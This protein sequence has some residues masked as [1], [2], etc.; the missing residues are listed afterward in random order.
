MWQKCNN[1]LSLAREKGK[2]GGERGGKIVTIVDFTVDL[3]TISQKCML[4]DH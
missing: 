1:L 2:G 4:T 3:L